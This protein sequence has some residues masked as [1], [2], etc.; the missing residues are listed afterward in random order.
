MSENLGSND[1]GLHFHRTVHY[2]L[3]ML[4]ALAHLHDPAEGFPADSADDLGQ[5][6]AILPQG[7]DE[8]GLLGQVRYITYAIDGTNAPCCGVPLSTL[9]NGDEV[10]QTDF[11][12]ASSS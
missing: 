7:D 2:L 4:L 3:E 1:L 9:G 12:R 6:W 10:L 8:W 11:I 5:C